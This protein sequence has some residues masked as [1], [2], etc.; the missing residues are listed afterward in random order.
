M[1]AFYFNSQHCFIWGLSLFLFSLPDTLYQYIILLFPV[2]VCIEMET[3][4]EWVLRW[5]FFLNLVA[6]LKQL[7]NEKPK[8]KKISNQLLYPSEECNKNVCSYIF[9]HRLP[10]LLVLSVVSIFVRSIFTTEEKDTEIS[11]LMNIQKFLNF[12]IGVLKTGLNLYFDIQ[13]V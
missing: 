3:C 2:G 13:D 9:V 10:T 4:W 8:Y 6:I 7:T 1:V 11:A 5:T 12:F